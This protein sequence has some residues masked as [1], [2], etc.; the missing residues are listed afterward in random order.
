VALRLCTVPWFLE[1]LYRT[2]RRESLHYKRNFYC[3]FGVFGT[4]WLLSYPVIVM[5]TA[6]Q[7]TF[8]RTKTVNVLDQIVILLTYVAWLLIFT[9]YRSY[10]RK[11]DGRQVDY[12]SNI[13]QQEDDFNDIGMDTL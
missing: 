4:V 11:G 9:P 12:N 7:E 13:A 1:C 8:H 3:G 5:I 10:M 6:A 2:Y